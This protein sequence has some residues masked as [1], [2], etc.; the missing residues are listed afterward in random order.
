[1]AEPSACDLAADLA[2]GN[3]TALEATET[4]LARIALDEPRVHA[5]AHRNP[6]HTRAQARRLDERR[7]AGGAIGPLHGVPVAVKDIVDTTDFPTE[8]GSALHAGR[9]PAQDAA[10]VVRLRTA[11]A[12]IPGKTVTTE[13]ACF[14]PGPTRNPHDPERTPGGSSSG[15][16]A[17]VAAGMVPLAIG[18]QTNGSVIRPASFCGVIGFKPS[19]GLVP[20]TGVLSTSATLDHVGVFARSVEDV[21]LLVDVLAGFDAGDPATRPVPPPALRRVSAEPPPATPR[22]AFVRGPTWDEA[23]LTTRDAFAELTRRLGAAVTEAALPVEFDPAVA[24][25]RVVWTVEL[26]HHLARENTQGREQLSGKLRELI[27]A[28]HA[29]S[30]PDYLAALQQRLALRAG[31]ERLFQEFDAIV[32]PAAPGEA[33]RGLAATGSPAFCSLWSLTGVPAISLPILCGPAGL[34]LGCQLVGAPGDDA[35]LL[36]TAR[37]LMGEV[38]GG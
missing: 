11:G 22:L 32:T 21:A 30:A 28:G 38:A 2:G 5:F 19:F 26:A 24:I 8:N 4:C 31:L 29:T 13:F 36:R 34:P 7:A 18:S 27:D 14:T 9:R 33:P 20:R 10:I 12:V 6:D 37:W 25:H 35:R 3:V 1:M 15:S 17:A 16:A 23:E